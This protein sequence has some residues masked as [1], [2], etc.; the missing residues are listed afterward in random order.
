MGKSRGNLS[1]MSNKVESVV[2][3]S[4]KI[5]IVIAMMSIYAIMVVTSTDVFARYI[6]GHALGWAYHMSGAL[7]VWIVFAGLSKV[8][9]EDGHIRVVVVFDLLKGRRRRVAQMLHDSI[10]IV[11]FG[12]IG[13]QSTIYMIMTLREG[14]P[15]APEWPVSSAVVWVIIALGCLLTCLRLTFSLAKRFYFRSVEGVR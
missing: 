2:S 15:Y 13:W 9:G 1:V 3:W 7:L 4:E 12:A 11:V 14:Y 8:T 6:L 5:G 10:G